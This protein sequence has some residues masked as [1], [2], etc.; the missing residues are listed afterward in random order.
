MVP[1]LCLI[2]YIKLFKGKTPVFSIVIL[3]KHLYKQTNIVTQKAKH[4]C[5]TTTHLY[6]DIKQEKAVLS[7]P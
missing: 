3:L 6:T 5:L 7:E 2:F 1:F 4:S